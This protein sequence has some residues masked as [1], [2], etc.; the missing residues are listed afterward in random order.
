MRSSRWAK[1][2]PEIA[3]L[4]PKELE[5]FML[6]EFGNSAGGGG[7]EADVWRQRVRSCGATTL[8]EL[9]SALTA[10]VSKAAA[11]SLP[12]AASTQ[13]TTKNA[14]SSTT[15]TAL[16]LAERCGWQCVWVE[17]LRAR[18]NAVFTVPKSAAAL[19]GAAAALLHGRAKKTKAKKTIPTNKKLQMK[20]KKSQSLSQKFEDH[21]HAGHHSAIDVRA[22]RHALAAASAAV[23][24]KLQRSKEEK[25]TFNFNAAKVFSQALAVASSSSP[26]SP[27]TM[28]TAAAAAASAAASASSS[29]PGLSAV[30]PQVPSATAAAAAAA[31]TAAAAASLVDI[32]PAIAK[33]IAKREKGKVA[34]HKAQKTLS[35]RR[36]SLTAL[37]AFTKAMGGMGGRNRGSSAAAHAVASASSASASAPATVSVPA[38]S[39]SD[40]KLAKSLWLRLSETQRQELIARAHHG[41]SIDAT[42]LRQRIDERVAVAENSP[43]TISSSSSSSS[44]IGATSSSSSLSP[45][46]MRASSASGAS[47][48]TPKSPS[49]GATAT[50]PRSPSL[51]PRAPP[52]ER[53]R[54]KSS[55]GGREGSGAGVSSTLTN[56]LA[57]MAEAEF[58]EHLGSFLAVLG[59][60]GSFGAEDGSGGGEE[61]EEERARE[62]G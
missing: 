35:M 39:A 52:R 62:A 31:A 41:R 57:T 24:C 17:P 61:E 33:A 56:A 37:E 30:E 58:E 51:L 47:T 22:A 23:E 28:S 53:R 15:T 5:S 4:L 59:G 12:A 45:A 7:W 29:A 44:S 8:L 48:G 19:S 1:G 60:G 42:T 36:E 50:P 25:G 14:S 3:L 54:K 13:S 27:S 9:R 16:T 38:R 21:H 20:S 6:R 18:I 40:L 34:Q 10:S 2:L 11:A 32:P 43:R 55:S 49:L 46:V 26:S